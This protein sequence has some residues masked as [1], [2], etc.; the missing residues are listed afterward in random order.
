MSFKHSMQ[1]SVALL[2]ALLAGC[3]GPAARPGGQTPVDDAPALTLEQPT[4]TGQPQNND[5]GQDGVDPVSTDTPAVEPTEDLGPEATDEP[6]VGNPNESPTD[7]PAPP[8]YAV[9][10]VK[11]S[12]ALA[13]RQEAVANSK[14]VSTLPYNARGLTKTGAKAQVGKDTWVEVFSSTVAVNGWVNSNN[15]T[16][17]VDPK[18]FCRDKQNVDLLNNLRKAITAMDGKLFSSLVSPVHGLN[19]RYYLTGTN[20][21]YTPEEASWVFSSTYSLNWGHAP[22]NDVITQGTFREIPLPVLHDTLKSMQKPVCNDAALAGAVANPWP[23]EYA[24]INFYTLHKS[25]PSNEMD[26]HTWLVGVEYVNGKPYLFAMI[27]FQWEP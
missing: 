6:A 1:I 10:L 19:L 21:N 27:H 24:N 25:N 11:S 12:A 18:V 17:D 3:S 4:D 2:V 23:A 14:V 9:L 5:A 8:T 20:A 15:L 22:G 16:E 26:W 7:Q 13:V